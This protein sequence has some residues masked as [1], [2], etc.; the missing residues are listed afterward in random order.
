MR[1][2]NHCDSVTYDFTMIID[3]MCSMDIVFKLSQ[4]T[5]SVLLFNFF[6]MCLIYFNKY[7]MFC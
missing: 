4:K 7:P 5:L 3:I 2:K 6:T 1:F